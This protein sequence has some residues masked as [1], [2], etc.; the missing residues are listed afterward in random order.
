MFFISI[1]SIGGCDIDFG[2]TGED[3][4]NGNGSIVGDII[5]EGVI[6]N[7]AEIGQVTITAT[8][9]NFRLDRTTTDETGNFRLQFRTSNDNVTLEF[10][11]D[12]F[13]AERPNIRVVGNSTTILDITL[14]QNPSLISIDRWQVFQNTISLFTDTT[15]D[16]V[17]SQVEFNIEGNG[18]NCIFVS[19]TS[20]I[21]YQ[22]KS[23][24]ITD[25]REGIR[26]QTEGSVILQADESIVLSSD[27][28][29]II[30]LDTSSVEI[31]QTTNPIN[32]TVSI[33]SNQ[34]GIN[35]GGT[36]VV[37]INPEN[38][39]S[40]SGGRE[41]VNDFGSGSVSTSNCTLSL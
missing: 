35:A 4:G 18:G 21:T 1:L 32:N 7:F 14:Q 36:S 13:D 31:G 38:E 29:A 34:F 20:S 30:T 22:V 25:C 6:V 23:I 9:N 37:T 12:S 40:I 27:Q 39:C 24:N 26:T 33:A 28:D 5:V 11:A 16:F 8:E 3:N 17:E 2:G 41:A 19:G 15:L 10:E